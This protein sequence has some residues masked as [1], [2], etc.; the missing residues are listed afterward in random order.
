MGSSNCDVTKVVTEQGKYEAM[1]RDVRKSTTIL[2]VH[3]G[4]FLVCTVSCLA[5]FTFEF[6]ASLYGQNNGIL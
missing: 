1:M 6:I 2:Y 3:G 5:S 4:G